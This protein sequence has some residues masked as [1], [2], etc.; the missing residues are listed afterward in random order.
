MG[1]LLKKARS[2]VWIGRRLGVARLH[3]KWGL[4]RS[5][6]RS[7]RPRVHAGRSPK[8]GSHD[9]RTKSCAVK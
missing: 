2:R 6:N 1:C 9:D 8:V 7:R 3:L 4:M 5:E